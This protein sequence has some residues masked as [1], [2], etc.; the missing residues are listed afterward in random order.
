MNQS[1]RNWLK[2]SHS[3]DFV[4]SPI[5]T[6]E[7]ERIRPQ[8]LNGMG[9]LVGTVSVNDYA[10]A[11]FVDGELNMQFMGRLGSG[12]RSIADSINDDSFAVGW[13]SVDVKNEK[14]LVGVRP[15]E[16]RALRKVDHRPLDAIRS[17]SGA[18][19]VEERGI[20]AQSRHSE[21]PSPR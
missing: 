17:G 21:A 12:T 10:E 14:Q 5:P 1:R 6:Y 2:T 4:S 13:A 20:R 9:E 3:D 16:S 18:K 19:G 7:G 11:V 8:G 15:V